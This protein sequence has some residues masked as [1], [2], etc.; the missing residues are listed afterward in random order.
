MHT[1]GRCYYVRVFYVGQD[2]H[3]RLALLKSKGDLLLLGFDRWD[4]YDYK[5]TFPVQC[6]IE[7]E[8][9]VT[10]AIKIL[11]SG[12]KVS[13]NYLESLV[14]QGWDGEFPVPNVN[15]VSV[16]SNTT[17]YEQIDGYIGNAATL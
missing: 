2:S 8:D 10:G 1:Q 11:F 6:R 3:K 13:Y 14:T 4:D 9:V 5:T 17:F 12:E 15:Y 16:P 7:G